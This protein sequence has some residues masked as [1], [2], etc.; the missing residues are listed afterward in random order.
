MLDT[1]LAATCSKAY[2]LY[3]VKWE[4]LSDSCNSWITEAELLKHSREVTAGDLEPG[5]SEILKEEE[6]DAEHGFGDTT[7]DLI[8]D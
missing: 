3:L 4:R 1:K 8:H 5:G 2:K 7:A 6:D